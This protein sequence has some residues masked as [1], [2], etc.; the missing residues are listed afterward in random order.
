VRSGFDRPNISFDTVALEGKGSKARKLALLEHGLR[1]G[2]NRPAIVYCGTRRDSE[3]V[4][5]SLRAAGVPAAAY[6]AGMAPDERASAQHR[7]MSG[8]AEVATNAF[9]GHRQGRRA[10]V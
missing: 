6:H 3:S 5:E 10:L 8:D 2:E 7:F 1:E 9:A 4:A